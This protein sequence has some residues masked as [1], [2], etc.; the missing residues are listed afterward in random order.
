VINL[1]GIGRPLLWILL[2]GVSGCAY[3][4]TLPTI[5]G[6]REF[7]SEQLP[8]IKAGM[9][10]VD[11]RGLLGEPF[12]TGTGTSP[13]RWRYFVRITGGDI[14]TLFGLVVQDRRRTATLD[15]MITFANDAVASVDTHRT[16]T[17]GRPK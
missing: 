13:V 11:V 2:L 9:S 5:T 6:G 1:N 17:P 3:G 16:V 7:Y 8:D 10:P 14:V 12:D 4:H 15:V